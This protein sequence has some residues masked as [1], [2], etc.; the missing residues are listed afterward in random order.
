MLVRAL[1]FALPTRACSP[2]KSAYCSGPAGSPGPPQSSTGSGRLR[3]REITCQER[4]SIQGNPA[5][6]KAAFLLAETAWVCQT[7]TTSK[8]RLDL[9]QRTTRSGTYAYQPCQAV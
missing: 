5:E 9:A 4:T 8:I 6:V 2:E 1:E 7:S 3:K